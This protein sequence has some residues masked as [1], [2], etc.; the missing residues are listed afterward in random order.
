MHDGLAHGW[1]EQASQ[2]TF[3]HDV[4]AAGAALAPGLPYVAKWGP[5]EGFIGDGR[6]AR[7]QAERVQ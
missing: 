7:C 6:L 3:R 4:V 5:D 2:T 1:D